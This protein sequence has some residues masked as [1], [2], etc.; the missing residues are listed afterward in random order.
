MVRCCDHLIS[1]SQGTLAYEPLPG[2]TF[3]GYFRDQCYDFKK[4]F[5]K[6]LAKKWHF[7]LKLLLVFEKKL[8]MTLVFEKNAN[9]ENWQKSQKIVTITSTP[10]QYRV[11]RKQCAHSS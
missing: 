11:Y 7:L 6:N 1:G 10:G 3:Y 4:I 9:F 5:A 8:I 2:I